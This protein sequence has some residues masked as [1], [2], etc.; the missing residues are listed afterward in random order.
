MND[1]FMSKGIC[2]FMIKDFRLYKE[3]TVNLSFRVCDLM[4]FPL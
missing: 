1:N 3:I 2:L 4:I